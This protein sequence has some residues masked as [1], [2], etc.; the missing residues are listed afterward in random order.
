VLQTHLPITACN[1]ALPGHITQHF[2]G[3]VR[4]CRFRSESG[5]EVEDEV[6]IM[7]ARECHAQRS[8][9]VPTLMLLLLLFQVFAVGINAEKRLCS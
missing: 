4:V 1:Q 7:A 9:S 3:S 5:V 8:A 2:G 6:V